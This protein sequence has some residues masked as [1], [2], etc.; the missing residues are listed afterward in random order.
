MIDIIII[1]ANIFILQ[2]RDLNLS[3]AKK[4]KLLSR[5]IGNWFYVSFVPE[6]RWSS[7]LYKIAWA[8][9]FKS[10]SGIFF[11]LSS[12]SWVI[13]KTIHL[14]PAI[15]SSLSFK[16]YFSKITRNQKYNLTFNYYEISFSFTYFDFWDLV[17]TSILLSGIGI[18]TSLL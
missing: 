3:G 18:S 5:R 9:N 12:E 1:I 14:D 6:P 17:I 13:P 11:S 7:M 8:F 15:C 2:I 10:V 4:L 16:K